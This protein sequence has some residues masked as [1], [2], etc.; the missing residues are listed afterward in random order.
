MVTRASCVEGLSSQG[1]DAWC[2]HPHREPGTSWATGRWRDLD[3]GQQDQG[4][5]VA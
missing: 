1:R 4:Q 2:G 5:N 3:Q